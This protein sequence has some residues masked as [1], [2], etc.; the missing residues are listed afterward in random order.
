MC[1]SPAIRCCFSVQKTTLTHRF[2]VSA[3]PCLTG[4]PT[5]PV[6]RASEGLLDSATVNFDAVPFAT[7]YSLRLLRCTGTVKDTCTEDAGSKPS[8]ANAGQHTFSTI[9]TAGLYVIEVKATAANS[10]SS[11]ATTTGI[12][13][14][15]KPG[16][17]A[18]PTVTPG[19]GNATF[20]WEAPAVNPDPTGVVDATRYTLRVYTPDGSTL[21]STQELSG[22][23]G[24]GT[25]PA[26]FTKLVTL[27]AGELL[28]L[29]VHRG[30]VL[31]KDAVAALLGA[32]ML[33]DVSACSG[34]LLHRA[35]LEHTMRHHFVQAL[36]RQLSLP[37]TCTARARSRSRRTSSQL[38]SPASPPL[39]RCR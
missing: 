33:A 10:V 31:G 28:W 24:Q 27:V 39:T 35:E 21:V 12:L 1:Q 19:V 34:A 26:P 23:G 3:F 18:K 17:P 25:G 16:A 4:K 32:A 7:G 2:C 15:G 6:T 37:P 13:L 22:L 9:T 29:D 20:S 8:E 5:A 11:D 38:G 36:G 30:F 14:V